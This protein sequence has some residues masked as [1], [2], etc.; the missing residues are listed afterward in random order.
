MANFR[1]LALSLTIAVC[2]F[3]FAQIQAQTDSTF[4]STEL[5]GPFSIGHV[6]TKT[7]YAKII[8]VHLRE[9][10]HDGWP[11]SDTCLVVLDSAGNSLLC[12][13]LDAVLG[14]SK[15]EFYCFQHTIP[16]VGS[17]LACSQEVYPSAGE[18]GFTTMFAFNSK[19][20]FVDVVEPLSEF[21]GKIVYLDT[22]S[23]IRPVFADS[24]R[25]YA[26]PA[27][28]T[29][30]WTG[31]FAA[32]EY[33]RIFPEGVPEDNQPLTYVF[34]EIP[35]EIDSAQAVRNRRRDDEG[36]RTI[37]LLS[38]PGSPT[39]KIKTI[40]IRPDTV[41]RFLNALHSNVWWLHIIVDGHEGFVGEED[42][43]SIGLPP[44][45]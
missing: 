28:Q 9:G 21:P 17:V 38:K 43:W 8:H 3:S 1:R 29:T 40:R 14:S 18:S 45:G 25:P 15:T 13:G 5:L 11:D 44:A 7:I 37:H 42:F 10:Q 33:H 16:I 30:L 26:Q 32:K 36:A 19:G 4:S 23:M 20:K 2:S 35:V 41:I 22:R 31:N 6:S 12:W 39:S 24:T 27:I 34:K